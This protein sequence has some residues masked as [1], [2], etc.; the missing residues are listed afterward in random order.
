M[1]KC[2]YVN[3][4]TGDLILAQTAVICRFLG[5]EFGMWPEKEEDVWHADQINTTIHDFIAEGLSNSIYYLFK[6]YIK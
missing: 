6:Q 4:P 2:M 1:N 5:K 3:V